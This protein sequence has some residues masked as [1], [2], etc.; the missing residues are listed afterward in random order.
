MSDFVKLIIKPRMLR[1]LH[2]FLHF[3]RC[4]Q[5]LTLFAMI[6]LLAV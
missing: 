5:L 2:I 1:A 3:T 6:I 4:M